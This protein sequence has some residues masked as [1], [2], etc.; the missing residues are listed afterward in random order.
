MG[1]EY[2]MINATKL[3][4]GSL[5]W[6]PQIGLRLVADV[7]PIRKSSIEKPFLAVLFKDHTPVACSD[8]QWQDSLVVQTMSDLKE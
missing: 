3:R 6:T 5:I 8:S 7:K 4:K 1:C 2:Y